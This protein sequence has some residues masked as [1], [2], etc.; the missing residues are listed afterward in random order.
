MAKIGGFDPGVGIQPLADGRGEIGRANLPAPARLI[1]WSLAE[2]AGTPVYGRL[3]ASALMDRFAPYLALDLKHRE[4]LAPDAFFAALENAAEAFRKEADER[5]EK[6]G[7]L[8][9][10]ARRLA[11]VLADRDLCAMLRNLVLKA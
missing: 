9:E 7:P 8:V 1:P 5:G 3:S 4:L 6:E 2:R 10:T 11:E